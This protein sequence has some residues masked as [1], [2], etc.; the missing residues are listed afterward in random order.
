MYKKILLGMS[1]F[2]I[3]IFDGFLENM[4]IVIFT[5]SIYK[6]FQ[7]KDTQNLFKC[8]V[9]SYIILNLVL[10]IFY[11][12]KVDYSILEPY[13]PQD[14]K[15]VILVYQGED[16]K[17]NLKER[18]REIYES[19]GVYSLFTSVYKLHRYKDMYE[20]LGSSEFKNR[21]YQF[22][23]EL[24]NKLGPNYTVLNSNLY[25]RP[26]LEN[27]VAD[28]VNKGYK[29][30]IFCPMFLTEG[31]EYKTFQKRVE[32]ME[33][34]KYGVNIKVT[35][36]FWD[37]EEIANVY[38][39][40]ILAYLNKKNDNMG[41]LLVGLKEQNDLNQDI[42]FREKIKNQ[43][44]NEKKDNIKIKLALL[45]NHKRD[46]IKIGEELLEYG[47]DLLYL[48]IPT[49]MFETIQIRSLAEYVLRK[50]YVSDETKYYYIGPVNDNSI[51]VEELYKKIKLIQN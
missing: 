24:S 44:L 2:S 7:N 48:V 11:K 15:A 14:K 13:N 47:I 41:I 28:L 22:R 25:T 32:N 1:F 33:L 43:L 46:I 4:F 38:K 5:I 50:L 29:E 21:S 12:E 8:F 16:R 26:Y 17:Y 36:V 10:V 19:D 45:E 30:I 37:S 23:K 31:R 9:I 42:I 51:L 18:S 35:G 27:I 49:S 6:A 20:K 3:L 40:N 34:I 39:D